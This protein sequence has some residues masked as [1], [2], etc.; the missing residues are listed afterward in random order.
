MSE[1]VSR[2][3]LCWLQS[4]AVRAPRSGGGEPLRKAAH[5]RQHWQAS[6]EPLNE[7]WVAL[8]PLR[9]QKV[10]LKKKAAGNRSDGYP[11]VSPSS[12]RFYQCHQIRQLARAP[13]RRERTA[14]K[15]VLW[16]WREHDTG[17]QG[18]PQC[19]LSSV[20]PCRY[21]SSLALHF[22]E[23]PSSS[24][25]SVLGSQSRTSISLPDITGCSR[26]WTRIF[27]ES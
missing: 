14:E 19:V 20:G 3:H 9:R 24:D 5:F 21:S 18:A 17:C 26:G 13:F 22:G 25:I 27:S 4:V 8:F 12:L 11:E 2:V 6:Q 16:D 15:E 1:R 7:I 23:R 10:P